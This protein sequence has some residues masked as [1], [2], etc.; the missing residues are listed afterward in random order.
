MVLRVKSPSLLIFLILP[1]FGCKKDIRNIQSQEISTPLPHPDHIIFVWFENKKYSSIIGSTDAPYINSLVASGTLFTNMHAI[2]HPSYPN[3]V[4]F[5][6]GQP[7]GITNDNCIDS[8]ALRAPNLFTELNSV[9]KSFAWYSEGLPLTGSIV[10]KSGYYVE[11]INP[12]PI[13]ANVP[14]SINKPFSTFPT[15]YTKLENVVCISPNLM[16]DMHDGSVSA[17]DE[18]LKTHL[19]SLAEWCRTHNSIFVIYFDEDD[20][21]AGNRIPVIALGQHVKVNYK[22]TTVYDH[23]NWTR[24][25]C[26]MFF[27]PSNWTTNLRTRTSINGCWQ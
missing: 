25:I 7:N 14:P 13:F 21:S 19:S 5:F 20:G 26:D 8:T 27:A 11:K 3:Y 10:C 23:Y 9:G 18:W 6:A 17:G 24:T 4:D 12:T 22:A 1:F 16:N 15:D 2:T